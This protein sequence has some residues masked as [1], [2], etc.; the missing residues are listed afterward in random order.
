MRLPDL[1]RLH[2]L[3]L[4]VA[5]GPSR[6]DVADYWNE[7]QEA[8]ESADYR[9]AL[10]NFVAARDAGLD[11]PAVHYNI[12]VAQYQLGHYAEAGA[13]FERIASRFPQMRALAH[14][15]LGLTATKQ[16]HA[17]AARRH[18]LK[19]HAAAADDRTLRILASRRLRE[20]EPGLVPDA[21]WTG[22]VGVRAGYDS[23]VALRDETGL[24]AG[25][26]T[27]SPMFDFFGTLQ[28]PESATGGFRGDA[29]VY[30]VRYPDARDFDQAEA[31][32]SGG[33]E[34]QSAVWRGRV[35][36]EAAAGSLASDAFDRRLGLH[37]SASRAVGASG[38]TEFALRY[39]DIDA[40]DETWAG[41]SG[42]RWIVDGRYSVTSGPHRVR[43]YYRHEANDRSDP[44]VSPS[45]DRWTVDYR[46]VASN[47]LSYE[48]GAEYRNSSYAELE[49]DR[50]EVLI[51]IRGAVSYT[52][53][54]RWLL[55]LDL[56]VAD[57]DS[58]DPAF[59][60]DRQVVSLGVLRLF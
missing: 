2:L 56:R 15:N 7:G 1:L 42:H 13:A 30:V 60:Y 32:L 35:A 37:A 47:S 46:F 43:L 40:A 5:V 25:N 29:S 12:A 38:F 59:E 9:A 24:P 31:R 39:D 18:F 53:S 50:K 20:L 4:I 44:G 22:A 55:L 16:G 11:T 33:Y 36:A 17:D 57:N 34:W 19:A 45:R 14:Y 52:I 8:W 27:D 58:T 10:D 54:D 26:S 21:A 6:A 3:V 23:N 28:S 48:L 41:I 51:T 49:D